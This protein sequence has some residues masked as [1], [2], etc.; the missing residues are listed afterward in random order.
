MRSSL[1]RQSTY[2]QIPYARDPLRQVQLRIDLFVLWPLRHQERIPCR[3]LPDRRIE[4]DDELDVQV[5]EFG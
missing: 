5:V 3:A 1:S 2:S 4:T